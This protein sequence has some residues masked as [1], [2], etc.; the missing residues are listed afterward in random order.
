MADSPSPRLH[1]GRPARIRRRRLYEDVMSRLETMIHE[2]V[3][4]AGSELPPERV[5][6]EQ[7]GVGRPAIREAL[8]ALQKM[9][10][11][12]LSPGERPR[13][14]KPAGDVII[15]SMRGAV[16]HFMMQPGGLR[17]FQSA[18]IFFEVGL[19]REAASHASPEALA[20]LQAALEENRSAL[21]NA[22]RFEKA[23]VEFHFQLAKMAANQLFLVLHD[24]MF[25]WLYTQRTVTLAVP[26]QAQIALQAH[27]AI[28]QAVLA[29]DA[30]H[31]EAEM[32]AHLEHG[33]KLY[34]DVMEH[35]GFTAEK[36]KDNLALAAALSVA[37]SSLKA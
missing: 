13:V 18:R 20:A 35:A 15:Q 26:G 17:Q 11:L 36:G 25:E 4:A 5:L 7:F 24:A 28:T 34:W 30:D 23:D 21:G 10:L 31:A 32:R 16:N 1:D 3:F 12:H 6:M 14:R 19:V 37:A 27:E 9:G 8:F 2:G 29:G 33:H 22:R